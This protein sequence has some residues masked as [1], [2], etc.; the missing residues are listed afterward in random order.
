VFHEVLVILFQIIEKKCFF[1]L[2]VRAH[3]K[4]KE[5]QAKNMSW[6]CEIAHELKSEK[7]IREIKKKYVF[8]KYLVHFFK[9][10]GSSYCLFQS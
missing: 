8:M 4:R 6:G 9:I 3:L 7:V 10:Y 1:C 5:N 2:V